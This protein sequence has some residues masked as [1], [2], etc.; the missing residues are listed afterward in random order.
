METFFWVNVVTSNGESR[1]GPYIQLQQALDIMMIHLPLLAP[2]LLIY[3]TTE[4]YITEEALEGT[5][6]TIITEKERC[7]FTQELPH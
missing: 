7:T 6:W 3:D 5:Q 4:R 2:S 1:L